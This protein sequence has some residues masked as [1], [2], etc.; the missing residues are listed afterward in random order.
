MKICA[1]DP[2]MWMIEGIDRGWSEFFVVG[3]RADSTSRP[4]AHRKN[5]PKSNIKGLAESLKIVPVYE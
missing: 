1:Q 4:L 5:I 2:R 3:E